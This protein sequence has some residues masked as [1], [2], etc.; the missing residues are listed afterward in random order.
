LHRAHALTTEL[1][2]PAGRFALQAAIAAEH[3]VAR[4]AEHTN[5]PRLATLYAIL[6]ERYPSPI[7]QLNRAV[8]VAM[9]DGPAAGLA[10]VEDL[11]GTGDVDGYYLLHAVRGDLLDRVGR[12]DEALA[13]FERAAGLTANLTEQQLLRDRI[14]RC[15]AVGADGLPSGRDGR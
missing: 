13:E 7:V 1:G 9:A 15:R 3:A 4:S 11:A 2:R 10:L 14:A 8:G 5:W 12:R 6:A